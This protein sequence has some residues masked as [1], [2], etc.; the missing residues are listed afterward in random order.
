M[1]GK[2]WRVDVSQKFIT[3]VSIFEFHIQ[4]SLGA[5]LG[6]KFR[7]DPPKKFFL[8]TIARARHDKFKFKEFHFQNKG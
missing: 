1:S 5:W 8:E 2:G 7:F 6:P 4:I 3:P